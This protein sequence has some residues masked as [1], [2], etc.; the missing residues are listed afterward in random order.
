M[1]P[2]QL[3]CV[4]RAFRFGGLV[5]ALANFHLIGPNDLSQAQA[6]IGA[7]CERGL[8]QNRV[9][10]YQIDL[11]KSRSVMAGL[12]PDHFCELHQFWRDWFAKEYARELRPFD[13]ALLLYHE[14]HLA[15]KCQRIG[16]AALDH[17]KLKT[18]SYLFEDLRARIRLA[19]TRLSPSIRREQ[20]NFIP[21]MMRYISE[22]QLLNDI[23]SPTELQEFMD[24]LTTQGENN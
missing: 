14:G 11:D 1:K 9:A 20:A 22:L 13:L 8:V 5:E 17:L 3:I 6:L 23:L 24:W 19:Q 12:S 2:E 18:R 7:W 15:V 21:N 16:A 10:Y 4:C